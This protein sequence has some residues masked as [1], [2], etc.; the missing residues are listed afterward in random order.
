MVLLV[1]LQNRSTGKDGWEVMGKRC[2]FYGEM[3]RYFGCLM[4]SGKIKSVAERIVNDYNHGKSI[5]VTIQHTGESGF[6]PN[7]SPYCKL[8]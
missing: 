3:L 1:A 8:E 7:G 4:V 5:V 2:S 6:F